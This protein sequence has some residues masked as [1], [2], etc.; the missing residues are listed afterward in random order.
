MNKNALLTCWSTCACKQHNPIS[1][2]F[3]AWSIIEFGHLWSKMKVQ[4]NRY[5]WH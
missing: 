3:T 1:P 2:G 4:W 5:M